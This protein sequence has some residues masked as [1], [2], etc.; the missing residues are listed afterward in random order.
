MKAK[1]VAL[2]QPIVA[3]TA[4]ATST[5]TTMTTATAAA[6][7][8]KSISTPTTTTAASTDASTTKKHHHRRRRHSLGRTTPPTPHPLID[9][10]VLRAAEFAQ[11]DCSITKTETFG[12]NSFP[13]VLTLKRCWKH[14]CA[15]ID[16]Q[17]ALAIVVRA[18]K[19]IVL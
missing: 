15:T 3:T 14:V 12:S 8:G 10:I 6:A 11:F 13:L 9:A 19:R 18:G 17:H 4:A 1:P 16:V 7:A 2:A 5:T